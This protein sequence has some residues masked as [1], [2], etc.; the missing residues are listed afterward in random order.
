MHRTL[1]IAVFTFTIAFVTG[2]QA[3]V[4][5]EAVVKG[6]GVLTCNGGGGARP[7]Y[8]SECRE[9]TINRISSPAGAIKY[10]I[11]CTDPNHTTFQLACDAFAFEKKGGA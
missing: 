9:V 2:L 4:L 7:L 8:N 1:W 6:K 11:T 10:E 3:E 5:S